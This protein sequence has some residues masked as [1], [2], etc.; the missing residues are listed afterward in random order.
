MSIAPAR[1]STLV[2]DALLLVMIVVWAGNYSLVKPALHELPPMA[3]NT[4]RLLLASAV[5]LGAVAWGRRH[6]ATLGPVGQAV[7]GPPVAVASRDWVTLAWLGVV[8]HTLYQ[9]GFMYAVA[10]TSV[11]NGALINGCSPI[12]IAVTA[13]AL[14][15]DRLGRPQW[16]GLVLSLVG[17]YLVAGH[18]AR[19]AAE[20][21]AGDLMMVLATLSWAVFTLGC[22]PLLARY[23][24]LV[25]LAY[26]MALG[27][28]PFALVAIPALLGVDWR[29]VA[30]SS[31]AAVVTSAVLALN[32]AYFV[33]YS[34]VQRI[35]PARTAICSN[36]VPIVAM[37][38]A[39]ITLGEAITASKVAGAVS[40]LSG[41]VLT[42]LAGRGGREELPPEE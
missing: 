42:R 4:L 7:V 32:L 16:A 6:Y 35:G 9:I 11:A 21:R 26:T 1:S 30:P 41:V 8:G 13:A 23:S 5:F 14:G 22:Q 34:S 3:F 15:K 17:L 10:W 2:T 27:A 40:I 36:V 25:V 19:T 18:G 33:Y 31:F 24:P 20:S 28:V 39:W 29:A 12:V 37:L 38:L